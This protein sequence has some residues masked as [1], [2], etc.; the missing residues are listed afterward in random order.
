MTSS[1]AA[2]TSSS[3]IGPVYVFLSGT[4]SD[5]I[6][7]DTS[8]TLISSM[9]G[10]SFASS[11]KYSTSI[12]VSVLKFSASNEPNDSTLLTGISE[13][14]SGSIFSSFISSTTGSGITTSSFASSTTGSGITTSSF[15]SST[16]GSGITTSSSFASSTTGS[17]ITTSSSFAS[18]TTGS[19]VYGITGVTI[20]LALDFAINSSSSS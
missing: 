3:I 5:D 20:G 11:S 7:S 18:S 17:G 14:S 1:N 6:F 9:T 10:S 13:I 19:F 8:S 16:T 12:E 4:S 15:A 2:L